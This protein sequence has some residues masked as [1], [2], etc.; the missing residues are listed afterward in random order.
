VRE[1]DGEV[2]GRVPGSVRGGGLPHLHSLA[3]FA[4]ATKVLDTV[5]VQ[6]NSKAWRRRHRQLEISVLQR[7]C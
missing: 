3:A 1:L 4:V 5:F 6:R 2:E 7:L